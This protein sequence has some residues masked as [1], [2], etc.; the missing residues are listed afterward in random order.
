M[1]ALVLAT[2]LLAVFLGLYAQSARTQSK[3]VAWILMRGGHVSYD[4]EEPL[5]DGSYPSNAKLPGP[6][7]LR[8]W[9]GIDYFSSVT[10]VILD[11]DEI[12]DLEPLTNLPHLRTLALM[13]YVSPHTDF[14]PLRR[15][16]HLESLHLAYNGIDP[17]FS[18]TIRQIVRGCK[19]INHDEFR[20]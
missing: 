5:A 2:S 7:W 12:D 9:L 14:S 19:I 15:L 13:N 8:R 4:Y 16:T 1:R 3:G 10:S 17:E 20:N 18:G 11:R 6:A